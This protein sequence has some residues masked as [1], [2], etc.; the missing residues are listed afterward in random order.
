MNVRETKKIKT[1]R[2]QRESIHLHMECRCENAAEI[3]IKVTKIA[4][5]TQ[6]RPNKP[7]VCE[8]LLTTK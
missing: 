7:D 2:E 1:K 3:M 4:V 6:I 5:K 8:R